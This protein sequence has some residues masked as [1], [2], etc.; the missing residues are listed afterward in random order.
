MASAFCVGTLHPLHKFVC[1]CGSPHGEAKTRNQ[2]WPWR[3]AAAVADGI[4]LLKRTLDNTV[5]FYPEAAVGPED[6][7]QA[8]AARPRQR[9]LGAAESS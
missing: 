5:K 6:S 1:N 3:L 4:S 8:E 2:V 7:Q 9:H